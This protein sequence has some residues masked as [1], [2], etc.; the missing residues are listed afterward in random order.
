M[1]QKAPRP[2]MA[3]AI[4]SLF[5]LFF[6]GC[7]LMPEVSGEGGAQH[8]EKLVRDG[9]HADSAR[10]FA[11][12]A[13]APSAQQDYYRLRAAE[14]WVE[15]NDLAAAEQILRTVSAEARTKQATL[16]ALVN[17]ELA[18][19]KNEGARAI[20]ELDAIQVP[21]SPDGAARYFLDK[22]RAAFSANRA[23]DAVRAYVERERWLSSASQLRSSRD[24]LYNN[25]RAAAER[26]ASLK[27]QGRADG[28]VAGWLELAP[29][30]V[31]LARNPMGAA[32][33]LAEWR[34]RFPVHPANDAVLPAAE[35]AVVDL[36]AAQLQIALLLP[37]SGRGESSGI[38]VRDGFLAAYLQ[39]AS[40][41]RPKLQIYDV[42]AESAVSAYQRAAA[43]GATFVVGPLTKEDVA[44]VAPL[45]EGRTPMLGLNFLSDDSSA[46]H[47]IFQFALLPEDDA[48]AVARRVAADGHREGLTILPASEWGR[49]IG[50]AFTDELSKQGGRVLDT[51]SYEPARTD[52]SEII[53]GLFQIKDAEKP[54]KGAKPLPP[55]F[56]T[57]ASFVFIAGNANAG[58]LIVPQLNFHYVGA[59]PTYSTA[60]SFEPDAAAN[61]DVDGLIFPDMPWMISGD[62]VTSH[63]RDQVHAA[64]PAK[65][66]RRGR[67][68]AFGFDAYRLVGALRGKTLDHGEVIAGM[69]G[70]LHLDS[71]G[72]I[73][74]DLDWA[75]IKGGVPRL[76]PSAM[77]IG[78]K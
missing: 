46:R 62:P 72:R 18:V 49:R 77:R 22:G 68:Y 11:Q 47:G 73:R 39:Q 10:A 17:A 60:D 78:Q 51:R 14:Q 20:R 15:A 48:R 53:R 75:Q 42:A 64:W 54:S 74:R 66:A 57:D 69:T 67:L 29:V 2:W 35:S 27:N 8:A 38:A 32:K 40:A 3:V 24:E 28:I 1:A 61:A 58:R 59:T 9:R 50:A 36:N 65:V 4:A 23:A 7:S 41:A 44:A 71:N 33:A 30:A 63:L 19:A 76:L 70:R 52:F 16:Y 13:A 6:S 12:L 25:L 26:G 43:D 5:G 34:Q 55:T 45:C 31:L 37:L 21:D 56:R